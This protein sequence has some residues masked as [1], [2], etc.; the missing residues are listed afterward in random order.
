MV[1]EAELDAVGADMAL[2][3]PYQEW[4]PT[5]TPP[6]ENS[7]EFPAVGNPTRLSGGCTFNGIPIADCGFL[8]RGSSFGSFRL[9]EASAEASRP[10][11]R[12]YE[13]SYINHKGEVVTA[14]NGLNGG[15][16]YA[17]AAEMS[18]TLTR[19]WLYT[20]TTWFF[21]ITAR[22]ANPQN[23]RPLSESEIN[24]L[25]EDLQNLLKNKQCSDVVKAILNKLARNTGV[26]PY[27]TDL[28]D[29]FDKI[30]KFDNKAG[31]YTAALGGNAGMVD[32][33]VIKGLS[34]SVNYPLLD[35]RFSR[36]MSGEVMI[37]ETTHAAPG[38]GTNSYFHYQMD[39]AA[40]DVA[41]DM[42]L[43][44]VG[45][46]VIGNRPLAPGK[47]DTSTSPFFNNMIF[48][49]CGNGVKR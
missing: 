9:V 38:S 8:M 34:L 33:H 36:I 32:A 40:W 25:R 28:M 1:Q 47:G 17:M 45:L 6:D 14:Y 24:Y 20:D 46:N 13:T 4:P 26:K 2:E 27:S 18:G 3:D 12:D 23:P 37:H 39:Q 44:R 42:D 21:G 30:T 43:S 10:R 15:F 35:Y 5:Y 41:K 19:N 22:L 7:P 31:P 11:L 49:F 48:A 16:A 29:I